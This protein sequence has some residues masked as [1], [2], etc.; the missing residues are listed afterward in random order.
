MFK[1]LLGLAFIFLII[2][3]L[4]AF[5]GFWLTDD[6]SSTCSYYIAIMFFLFFIFTSFLAL[7]F[8]D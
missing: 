3:G 6:F 4:I 5:Q 7:I 2:S 1:E 8:S